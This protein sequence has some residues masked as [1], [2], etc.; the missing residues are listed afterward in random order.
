MIIPPEKLDE[1]R[2]SNDI[3]D[4]IGSYIRLIRRGKSYVGL[5]PFHQ[6]KT[7]SFSVN[8]EKQMYYCFGCHAGGTVFTFLQ[9][10]EKLSFADSA[11]KLAERAGISLVFQEQDFE[12]D[13]EVLYSLNEIATEYF[14]NNLQSTVG[15]FSKEY[16]LK[17]DITEETISKFKLGF[18]VNSWEDFSNYAKSVGLDLE[19]LNKLG[20]VGKNQN[21]YFDFFRGRIMFPI[22]SI[23]GKVAGFGARQIAESKDSGKYI[24]SKDSEVYNKSKILYG[25]NFSKDEIR[26]NDCAILVEGYM[27]Y[28]T[29]Y[30]N[31]IK[32]IVASSGTALTAD[33]VKILSRYTRKLLFLYDADSAGI[34]ATIRSLDVVFENGFDVKIVSL[35]NNE[36]PDSYV[37]KYGVS[38]FQDSL[39]KAVSFIHF[40]SDV[41]R[42][43]GKF[44]STQGLTESVREMLSLLAKVKD[45]LKL[46]FYLKELAEGF[47]IS[48]GLVRKEF[49][50]L[51]KNSL[52]QSIKKDNKTYEL[53]KA[54]EK[55]FVDRG[56][57]YPTKEEEDLI[58]LIILDGKKII[59]FIDDNL[60]ESEI[61]SDITK[62][63][64]KYL[65]GLLDTYG[66]LTEDIILGGTDDKEISGIITKLYLQKK[67][68]SIDEAASKYED[69]E[70]SKLKWGK[71]II[72]KIKI[73]SIDTKINQIKKMIKNAESENVDCTD[74][75]AQHNELIE[76]RR[77]WYEI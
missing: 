26:K 74:L 1:I 43:T 28:L 38:K 36:D 8:P 25:L 44:E 14:Y 77:S 21:G 11:K 4:I 65:L 67:E 61:K 51:N 10:Y 48:E 29:L 13:K 46:E 40:M 53:K 50:I 49:D 5:C 19:L 17:R 30:Q 23:M 2:S 58:A 20:L 32:N 70:A 37:R 56:I 24:N 62:K 33:Q 15:K 6:E 22:F 34:K 45:N 16:F 60:S 76:R 68:L 27:D 69:F 71:D 35:G 18:S 7:P 52:N 64:I 75:V 42:N 66:E 12:K 47:D 73:N 3:V 59:N 72:K 57:I 41:Y 54:P 31:G 39:D 55:I 9:Q 63:I